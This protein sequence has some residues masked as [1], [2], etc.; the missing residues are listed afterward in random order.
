M[1]EKRQ[2][3]EFNRSVKSGQ[4]NIVL[5]FQNQQKLFVHFCLKDIHDQ[6]K[7]PAYVLLNSL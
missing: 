1:S 2:A 7:R 6:Y 4:I 5:V 3:E